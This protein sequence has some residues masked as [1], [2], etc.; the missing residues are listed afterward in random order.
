MEAHQQTAKPSEASEA[1]R[2]TTVSGVSIEK[3]AEIKMLATR[4][5]DNERS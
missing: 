3:Q 5:K 4:S 1:V 2:A